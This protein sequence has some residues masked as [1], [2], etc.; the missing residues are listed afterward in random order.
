[1]TDPVLQAAPVANDER[2]EDVADQAIP[3]GAVPENERLKISGY[4]VSDEAYPIRR[5]SRER[6][7]M[8]RS[9]NKYAYRCLPL[10]IASQMGWELLSPVDFA[11][12]WT[13]EDAQDALTVR[14]FGRGTGTITSHFGMGVLS[15]NLGWMFRTPPGIGMLCVGPANDPKP[16]IGPLE[17]F[18]ETDWSD[19]TF[20][21]NWRFSEAGEVFFRKGEPICRIVPYPQYFLDQFDGELLMK[22]DMPQQSGEEYGA[23]DKARGEFLTGLKNKDEAA[24][25]LGWMRHYMRGVK[26]LSGEKVKTHQTKFG[27]RD[28][29]DLRGGRGSEKR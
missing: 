13:G 3:V 11:A 10:V 16:K 6:A 15:F 28:F 14:F 29:V 23:W 12:T 18:I 24:V 8:D 5:A 1:M 2:P 27:H 22:S 19:Y 21:M 20:L 25:K 7:W 4:Q 9:P 17:G 26:F